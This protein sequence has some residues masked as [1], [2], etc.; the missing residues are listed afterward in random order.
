MDEM[1]CGKDVYSN[2]KVILS[3]TMIELIFE[4]EIEIVMLIETVL[5]FV[6][7]IGIEIVI[8]LVYVIVNGEG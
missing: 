3:I 1:R 6:I 2:V 4:I 5:E 8:E 7:V